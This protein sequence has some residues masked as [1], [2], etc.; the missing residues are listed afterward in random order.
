M[1]QSETSQV[2]RSLPDLKGFAF[3]LDGTIWEG[4]TLLPDAATLIADI[5]SAGLGVVFASN[6]SRHGASI[7]CRQL[8]DW[9]SMRPPPRASR[10]S[11]WSAKPS[12]ERWGPCEYWSSVRMILPRC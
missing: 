2:P 8:A 1:G 10:R 12:S 9:E 4:P 7:L 5:R 3:D 6:C 11:I